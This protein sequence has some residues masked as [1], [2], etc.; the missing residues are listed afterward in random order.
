MKEPKFFNQRVGSDTYPWQVL[1]VLT[2]G[3]RYK[4]R[5][6]KFDHCYNVEGGGKPE[7]DESGEEV[8]VSKRKSGGFYQVGTNCCRFYPSDTPPGYIDPS[9]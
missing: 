9:F 2:P 6:M 5:E 1:K 7:E 8:V 4:V 3:R